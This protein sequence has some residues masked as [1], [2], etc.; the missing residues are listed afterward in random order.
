MG[1]TTAAMDTRKCSRCR[2]STWPAVDNGGRAGLPV[3]LDPTPL[4]SMGELGALLTGR[5]TYTVHRN[6]DVH[7]RT[8]QSIRGRPAGRTLRQTVHADHACTDQGDT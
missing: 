5:R 2:A 1:T 8:V 7:A 6:G 4:D 3:V